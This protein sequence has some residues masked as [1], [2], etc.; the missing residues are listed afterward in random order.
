MEKEMQYDA[1]DYLYA[2][3]QSADW[4]SSGYK[5]LA[6]KYRNNR[7]IKELYMCICDNVNIDL[8]ELI[9]VDEDTS[10]V[11]MKC[12]KKHLESD[13][14]RKYQDAID[15]ITL[16][17]KST[18]YE[19]KSLSGTVKQIAETMPIKEELFYVP[20]TNEEIDTQTMLEESM[21]DEEV[22]PKFGTKIENKDKNESIFPSTLEFSKSSSNSWIDV[23]KQCFSYL[24]KKQKKNTKKTVMSMLE[25]GY[26]DE[27]INFI[28]KCFVEG[29]TEKEIDEIADPSLSLQ[30]MELLKKIK[31][32]EREKHGIR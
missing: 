4:I 17:T 8:L 14:T 32:K 23:F 3:I 1:Y 5:E 21:Q 24:F 29:M 16:I 6:E 22:V 11:L 9:T 26:K 13:F 15:R 7:A 20:T 27:Q 31:M 12:R 18:E 28:L 30:N 2:T 19:I 10:D 25:Q